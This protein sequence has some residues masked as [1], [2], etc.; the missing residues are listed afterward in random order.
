[1]ASVKLISKTPTPGGP[2]GTHVYEYECTCDTGA[3]HPITV[4]SLDDEDARRQAQRK[5]DQKCSTVQS[6]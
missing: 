2:P 1:V 6:A 5:C 3:K 4:V